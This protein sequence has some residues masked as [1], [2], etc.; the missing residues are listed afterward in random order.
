MVYQIDLH[1]NFLNQ[2]KKMWP[3]QPGLVYVHSIF[4]DNKTV[5]P[6]FMCF[7]IGYKAV[8]AMSN[9]WLSSK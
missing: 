7:S 3:M 4:V 2:S 8:K 1:A 5:L 6:S 9:K